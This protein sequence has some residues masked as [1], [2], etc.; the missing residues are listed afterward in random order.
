MTYEKWSNNKLAK[1]AVVAAIL[2]CPETAGV[3]CPI[4][5]D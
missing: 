2:Y 5:D 4:F 3:C 1:M